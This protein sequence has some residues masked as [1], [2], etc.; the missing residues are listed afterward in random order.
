MT[1]ALWVYA[2]TRGPLPDSWSDRPTGVGGTAVEAVEAAGLVA[3]VG[4]VD[5]GEYGAEALHRNLSDLPWLEATARAHHEVTAAAWRHGPVVPV[6]LATVYRTEEAIRAVL[7]D[8][9]T[10]LCEVLEQITGR[11]EW[12][13]KGYATRTSAEGLHAAARP[14]DAG[15]PAN[16]PGAGADYLRRRRA[17]LAAAEA[18]QDAAARS[19]AAVHAELT[20][21]AESARRH[22]PQERALSG[23]SDWM[24]LNGAY[25]VATTRE[26]EFHDVVRELRTRH[27]ALRLDLTGPWPPYSF[28]VLA[29]GVAGSAEEGAR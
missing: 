8:R 3:L 19:A 18:A 6:R 4:R 28:A 20:R 26:E 29:D 15:R 2:L 24:A 22:R 11:A 12:G 13:V 16:A 9:R 14:T 5:P 23:V 10:E 27:P 1:P 17:S 25:L 7:T 21:Y